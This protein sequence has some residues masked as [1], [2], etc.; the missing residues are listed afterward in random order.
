MSE[1][2]IRLVDCDLEEPLGLE[3]VAEAVGARPA[4]ISRLVRM[5]LLETIP[6]NEGGSL[7]PAGATSALTLRAPPSSLTWWTAF[8]G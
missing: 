3:A 7:L 1:G 8:P 6:C 2:F 4:L 5:G